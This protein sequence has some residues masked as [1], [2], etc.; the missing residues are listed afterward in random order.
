[1]QPEPGAPLAELEEMT[2][3]PP[4]AQPKVEVETPVPDLA[5]KEEEKAD[6]KPDPKPETKPDTKPD[7]KPDNKPESGPDA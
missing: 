4:E 3:D 7:N 5:L 6:P 1:M 2:I